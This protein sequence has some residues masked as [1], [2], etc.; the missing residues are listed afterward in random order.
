M[1][2]HQVDDIE[3]DEKELG[4]LIRKIVKCV[5]YFCEVIAC[6]CVT[7]TG[8]LAD[9]LLSAGISSLEKKNY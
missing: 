5:S 1:I 6:L 8:Y 9:I 2:R 3:K 7:H 4:S